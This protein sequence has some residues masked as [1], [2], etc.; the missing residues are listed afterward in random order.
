VEATI[1]DLGIGYAFQIAL[2]PDGKQA[3][4]AMSKAAGSTVSSGVNRI[5]VIDTIENKIVK[6]IPFG[7]N[8]YGPTTVAMH[9][10]GKYLYTAH[11]GDH[12]IL[13]INTETNMILST[14]SSVGESPMDISVSADGSRL[15]VANRIE[16][17]L[18]IFDI[19]NT[20]RTLTFNQLIPLELDVS[21]GGYVFVGITPDDSRA[22][23]TTSF[24]SRIAVIDNPESE[25]YSVSYIEA[26]PDRRGIVISP[27]G[28][29]A[30]NTGSSALI[31]DIDPGSGTYGESL[32]TI[33][34]WSVG[35][36][37]ASPPEDKL[38]I[39]GVNFIKIITGIP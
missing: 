13:V 32:D 8:N 7:T 6:A 2:T 14:I 1:Q 36:V 20:G 26:I 31:I 22:Y 21:G 17:S 5:A 4:V 11:R 16:P 15:M 25:N 38:Y 33:T 3:Y 30:V 12:T 27:D 19:D 9:P 34:G 39:C 35:A 23:V 24:D 28:T 29:R 18:A 37:F 10:N